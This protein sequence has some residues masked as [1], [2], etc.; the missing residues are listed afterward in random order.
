MPNSNGRIYRDETTTP[1]KGVSFAD[2]QTVLGTNVNTE[3]GLCTHENINKWARW[4]PMRVGTLTPLTH[5]V[6]GNGANHFGLELIDGN[7]NT[8]KQ[9]V[10]EYVSLVYGSA[11]SASI[12]TKA[13]WSDG[14]KYIRP[15]GTLSSPYRVSDFASAENA[16]LGYLTTATLLYH[17]PDYSHTAPSHP[18][19]SSEISSLIQHDASGD[20]IA[21]DELPDTQDLPDDSSVFEAL[22]TPLSI[23]GKTHND[24][25]SISAIEL[26]KAAFGS[27]GFERGVVLVDTSGWVSEFNA[28]GIIPWGTWKSSQDEASLYGEWVCIEYYSDYNGSRFCMIP[29]FEYKVFFKYGSSPSQ[30][31]L[32][33]AKDPAI[34]MCVSSQNYKMFIS[35]CQITSENLSD[36][37]VYVSLI[38][39]N[40]GGTESV[41][42]SRANLNTFTTVTSGATWYQTYVNVDYPSQSHEGDI[43]KVK[44]E[45]KL[46]GTSQTERVFWLTNISLTV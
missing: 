23:T 4:K 14:V 35:F 1:P 36:W 16:N 3:S 27:N 22:N 37:D 26:I 24:Y 2:V 33:F 20:F 21:I 41:Y 25:N 43:F 31:E 40:T 46:T 42:L 45:Y 15:I 9:K 29:G 30:R 10:G 32:A 17:W 5:S 13:E 28:I 38:K 18:S 7:W 6:I 8:F 19:I 34:G 39:E 11:Q 12:G 44:I